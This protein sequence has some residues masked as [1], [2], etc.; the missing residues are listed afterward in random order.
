MVTDR[1]LP[2][3]YGIYSLRYSVSVLVLHGPV[4]GGELDLTLKVLLYRARLHGGKPKTVRRV[5]QLKYQ[6]TLSS[7]Y[8]D[9]I[10][11]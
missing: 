4:H 6:T 3:F 8:S 10:P 9:N 7:I 2:I 1:D 11:R 5:T